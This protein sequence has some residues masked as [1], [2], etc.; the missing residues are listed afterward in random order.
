MEIPRYICSTCD[1]TGQV[2][3]ATATWN[4]P[5]E[6]DECPDCNG[7]GYDTTVQVWI[8]PLPHLRTKEE[9]AK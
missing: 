7:E 6:C 4:H 9:Y 5:A 2:L 1:G 8:D 3:Y